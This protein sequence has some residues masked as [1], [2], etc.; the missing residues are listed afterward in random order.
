MC[1]SGFCQLTQP[2]PLWNCPKSC[3]LAFDGFW[4]PFD[5]LDSQL[6]SVA[7]TPTHRQGIGFSQG[8]F[9]FQR[10]KNPGLGLLM[11][12]QTRTGIFRFCGSASV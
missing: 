9:L 10:I 11:E 3:C 12:G 7:P 8:F 2:E 6:T 5:P 4:L 1:L